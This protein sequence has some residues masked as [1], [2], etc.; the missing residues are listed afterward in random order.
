[1]ALG[2]G[3]TLRHPLRRFGSSVCPFDLFL[4]FFPPFHDG[5]LAKSYRSGKAIVY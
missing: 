1:M 2:V 4:C 5:G 3:V